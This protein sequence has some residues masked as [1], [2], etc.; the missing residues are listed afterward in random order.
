[1]FASENNLESTKVPWVHEGSLNP[2]GKRVWNP[3]ENRKI[4]GLFKG[5]VKLDRQENIMQN[6]S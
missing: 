5:S 2:Q 6:N 4:R 1:M 3:P